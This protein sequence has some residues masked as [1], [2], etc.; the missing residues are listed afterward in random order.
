[1]EKW[2]CAVNFIPPVTC[3]QF[4]VQ[5]ISLQP[6][7]HWFIKT[8]KKDYYSS[9]LFSFHHF[10]QFRWFMLL[11]VWKFVQTLLNFAQLNLNFRLF[12]FNICRYNTWF[13]FLIISDLWRFV[14]FREVFWWIQ[15]VFYMLHFGSF[16]C[17]L[18][19]LFRLTLMLIFS[20]VSFFV[21]DLHIKLECAMLMFF[22][23]SLLYDA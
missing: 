12:V 3:R 20:Y 9:L 7:F 5:I 4:L 16:L 19:F 8:S 13:W 18:L 2:H 22:L 11:M 1:M 14:C 21:T 10:G 15:S 17:D 6:L 23:L